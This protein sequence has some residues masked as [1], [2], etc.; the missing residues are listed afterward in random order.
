MMS[1]S[2]AGTVTCGV[3]GLSR[4]AARIET[5]KN[6]ATEC[7]SASRGQFFKAGCLIFV[8]LES[9]DRRFDPA[10]DCGGTESRH[11][12]RIYKLSHEFSARK[13]QEFGTL[14]MK[15]SSIA[16]VA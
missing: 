16:S 6:R 15:P 9:A 5:A 13:L 11:A 2:A 1:F 8:R 4:C 7:V 10:I 12:R 3:T 14:F